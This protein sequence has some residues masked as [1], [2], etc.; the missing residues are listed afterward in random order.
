MVIIYL[1]NNVGEPI[2][3]LKYSQTI[4][5]VLY[6]TNKTRLNIAHAVRRLSKY[7]PK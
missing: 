5:F 3:Q 2:S 6:I 4:G 1:K 7:T